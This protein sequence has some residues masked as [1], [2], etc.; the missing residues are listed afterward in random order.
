M[1]ANGHSTALIDISELHLHLGTRA[2][3]KGLNLQLERGEF[4]VLLGANGAGKTSL[5]TILCGLHDYDRGDV[6][7]FSQS[8]ALHD[9]SLLARVGIVFQQ[10]SLDL[11][12]SVEQNLFYV[13]GLQGLS[14]RQARARIE[15]ALQHYG[16]IAQRSAPARELNGG[17]R[18]RLEL[19]RASL[20]EPELL[21]LDEATVGLDPLS[22]AQFVDEV[23]ELCKAQQLTVLWSTHL[24][25]EVRPDDRVFILHDGIIHT[26]DSAQQLC[27]QFHC[28]S[29]LEV[30]RLITSQRG[31]TGS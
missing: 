5:L 3:L 31:N 20:H 7:L 14:R 1:N 25:D 6:R 24:I 19:I 2:V 15:R 8:L 10:P 22:R 4:A 26:H 16:L 12:L 29:L 17:H 30:F 18:R 21:L 13:A 28:D 27:E 23:H 11:D 9:Q